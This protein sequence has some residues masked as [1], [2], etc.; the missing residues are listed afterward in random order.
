MATLP[1][2]ALM[3]RAAAGLAA[4]CARVLGGPYG[5][6]VVLL[7]GGG[8]NGGDALW[9]GARLAHRGA[10]VDAVLLRHDRVHPAGLAAFRRAGGRVVSSADVPL[11]P[12]TQ[13]A[14]A[15][16]DLV[17]DG[18]LGIGGR[19]GLRDDAAR[20]ADAAAAE[21]G[22]VVAVDLPSGVEPDTAELTG[23]HVRADVTVTFGT[24][25]L[26]ILADPA[27]QVAGHVEFVDIG[28]APY[29]PE[30]VAGMLEPVDVAEMLPA[31]E[32]NSDKYRRGVLGLL[33]GSAQFRGA[34]VLAAGGAAEGGA[35][36]VRFVGPDEVATQV[37]NR[38]PEVVTSAD[39]AD[40][41]RVQAWAVGSGL[42]DGRAAE[43]AAVLDTGLPVLVDADGLRHLPETLDGRALLTPH[44]GEL[45]RMMD[46]DRGDVEAHR[47]RYVQAAARRWN[48]TVL[49]KGSTTLVA[50]PDGRIRVNPTGTPALATAGS[51]DVLSGLA[52]AL[53][54]TGMEPFDAGSA[55]AYIH[56]LAGQAA[57]EG[58]G[59]PSASAVLDA[60]PA[61]LA[62]LHSA[63]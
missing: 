28:L 29:L 18:M 25:K 4:V 23:P 10:S 41:G 13:R 58:S 12:E 26:A 1:E 54:A 7:V 43:V 37:L 61:V 36:M 51:G 39:V 31:P 35:G 32:R 49:L 63:R 52:G 20:L 60:L 9:A 42:G 14:I 55:A 11:T 5:S 50:A 45:A 22:L 8:D 24:H 27:A 6:R 16:A 46:A 48:A 57:A 34:A 33:A 2:S 56:G 3:Q 59:L 62:A 38:W 30:P 40:T 53:L 47:L 44:A 21:A 17:L 15:R 19:G